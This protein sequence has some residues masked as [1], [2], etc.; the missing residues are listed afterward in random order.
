M[1][2]TKDEQ[3]MLTEFVFRIP[4]QY[5]EPSANDFPAHGSE[6]DLP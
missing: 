1:P 2:V 5:T 6:L 4:Y 3:G